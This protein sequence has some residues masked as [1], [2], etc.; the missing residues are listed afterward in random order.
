VQVGRSSRDTA[1]RDD[2]T[3]GTSVQHRMLLA[4]TAASPHAGDERDHLLDLGGRDV[5]SPADF[6]MSLARIANLR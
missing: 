1:V 5:F 4:T 6:S 2:E 3:T